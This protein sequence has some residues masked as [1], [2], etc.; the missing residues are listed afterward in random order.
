MLTYISNSFHYKELL[1]WVQ[2]VKHTLWIGTADIKDLY[3][4]VGK[5]KKPFLALIAQL[6]RRGVEVRLIHAKEPGQNFREDFDK[7][8]VLYDRL[9]RVLCPRVHFKMLVF[10]SKEVY[11]G[12]ANLT[13]AG[14]GMK[15]ETTRN[16]EAGILTDDPEIVVQ[17]MNGRSSERHPSLLEDA[18]VV[19]DEDEVNQFDEV[20]IDKHCKSCKRRDFCPD[21]IA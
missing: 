17:A 9:E 10:D 6:I 13:G 7:Y 21:P 19:T 20:W 3:V 18:R 12:S 11:I 1:S 14:I 15:A 5:E 8:P 16:F 2:S 4:E